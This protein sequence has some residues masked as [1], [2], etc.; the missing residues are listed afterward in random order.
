MENDFVT[1][2]NVCTT[3][4]GQR[5]TEIIVI[6]TKLSVNF[7]FRYSSRVI[8]NTYAKKLYGSR[9]NILNDAYPHIT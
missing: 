3:A 7:S 6:P 5:C 9:T 1:C 8:K 4:F 2:L